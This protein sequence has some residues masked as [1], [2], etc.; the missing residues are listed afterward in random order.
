MKHGVAKAIIKTNLK[1]NKLNTSAV[2]SAMQVG[3]ELLHGTK[4]EQAQR[5][6]SGAESLKRHCPDAR[7][8]LKIF[9]DLYEVTQVESEREESEESEE[10]E[11][12]GGRGSRRRRIAH[13][14]GRRNPE[15]FRGV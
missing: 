13:R 7:I 15:N 10:S 1:M 2:R 8:F 3:T 14:S 5:I 4:T 11:A 6:V 9:G 12:G